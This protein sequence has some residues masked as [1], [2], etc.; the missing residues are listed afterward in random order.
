MAGDEKKTHAEGG[1]VVAVVR[2]HELVQASAG[3]IDGNG[4]VSRGGRTVDH[5]VQVKGRDE[6]NGDVWDSRHILQ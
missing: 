6:R 5:L 2:E 3:V 1:G 4:G